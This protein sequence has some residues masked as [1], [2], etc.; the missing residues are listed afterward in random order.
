MAGM[1]LAAVILPIAIAYGQLSGLPPVAGVY[2]SIPP[3]ILYALFA[4]SPLLIVGPDASSTALM[5]TAVAPLA[6]GDPEKYA[7]AAATLAVLVGAVCLA[8]SLAR[9][10]FVANFLS[11][12]ILVGY[13]NGLALTVLASQLGRL[14]GVALHADT[15]FG[16]IGETI[17]RIGE[18][19]WLTLAIGASVLALVLVSRARYPQVPAT[20]VAVV[21]AT[22]VVYVFHLDARGVATLGIITAGLPLPSVPAVSAGELTTLLPAAVGI[23]LLTFSDTILNARIFAERAGREVDANRELAG[24]GASNLG[25][26]FFHGYPVSGS[27]ARTAVNMAAGAKTPLAGMCAALALVMILVLFTRQ[28]SLFPRAALGAVLFAAVLPLIDVGALIQLYR[29]RK[30]ELIVALVALIG[31]LVI[32]LLEAIALAIVLSLAVLLAR[33]VRPHDAVLGRVHGLDGFHDIGDYPESETIPG[34]LVYRFDAPLFFANANYFRERVHLLIA[35][36]D[37]PVRW[38]VLDAEAITDLD[39]TAAET[40]ERVRKELDRTGIVLVIAR[41]KHQ[42]WTRLDRSG[43]TNSIG[44]TRFFPTIR[45]SVQAF[46]RQERTI[47]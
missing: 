11:K 23:V 38:L 3:L 29:I 45:T 2:A 5:I 34:L 22:L 44:A 21:A 31:V 35:E 19:H 14:T 25:A 9:L 15:F 43:L 30:S 20:F 17:A 32:G 13:I 7:T 1:T 36:T 37:P 27:G 4:S 10:G 18:V 39:A 40:F 42:L 47:H 26:G 12:P 41:A 33:T 16:Q 8:C 28:I 46:I 24:L 6:A